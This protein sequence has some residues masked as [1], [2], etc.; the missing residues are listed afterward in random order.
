MRRGLSQPL[1]CRE[2]GHQPF[3]FVNRQP[4]K[5]YKER[6]NR[7]PTAL[8]S[9]PATKSFRIKA[10]STNE[11][12]IILRIHCCCKSGGKISPLPETS[13]ATLRN[14]GILERFSSAR[15]SRDW[16][17]PRDVRATLEMSDTASRTKEALRASKARL[18]SSRPSSREWRAGNCRSRNRLQPTS[19]APSCCNIARGVE[20]CSAPGADPRARRAEELRA[21]DA[22]TQGSDELDEP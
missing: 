13:L 7:P 12:K 3:L 11:L 17:P 8:L 9:Q 6:S 20:G 2:I 18:P 21:E 16:R 5:Q 4:N 15:F 14:W 22:M 1:A 10:A 19:V